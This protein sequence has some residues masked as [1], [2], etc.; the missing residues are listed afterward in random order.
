MKR[1]THAALLLAAVLAM[2]GSVLAQRPQPLTPQQANDLK[3]LILAQEG[4]NPFWQVEWLNDIW[5]AR[6]KAAAEGKPIFVWSG[7]EGAPI[8]NC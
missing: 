8:T 6:Q 3:D 7:S 2:Q 1:Q 5:E 4:E